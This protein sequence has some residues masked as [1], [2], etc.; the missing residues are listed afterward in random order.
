M[1]D[2]PEVDRWTR[3]KILRELIA[4]ADSETPR[5]AQQAVEQQGAIRFLRRKFDETASEVIT[6]D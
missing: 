5:T 6:G 1:P 4:D 3:A 2:A